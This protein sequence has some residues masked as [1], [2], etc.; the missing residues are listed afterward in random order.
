[1]KR[2]S[3]HLA[4]PTID[5]EYTPGSS[6]GAYLNSLLSHVSLQGRTG[7]LEMTRSQ[8]LTSIGISPHVFM[9]IS[10]TQPCALFLDMRINPQQQA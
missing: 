1:M 9:L 6:R 3:F 8:G 5:S 7:A 2:Q 10:T 4:F